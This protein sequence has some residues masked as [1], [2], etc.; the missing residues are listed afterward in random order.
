APRAPGR[1]GAPAEPWHPWISRDVKPRRIPAR[2]SYLVGLEERE[3]AK[4]FVRLLGQLLGDDFKA[5]V[6]N[7]VSDPGVVLTWRKGATEV[8]AIFTQTGA[9]Y[10]VITYDGGPIVQHR[11]LSGFD[12]EFAKIRRKLVP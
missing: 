5:P 12:K 11:P 6:V 2:R 4:A 9:R 3:S 1:S 8:N 10:A 7:P